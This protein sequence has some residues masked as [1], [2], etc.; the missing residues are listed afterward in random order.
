MENRNKEFDYTIVLD[1]NYTGPD[2]KT[3]NR[4]KPRSRLQQSL[5]I[6]MRKQTACIMNTRRSVSATR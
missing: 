3:S 4:R 2:R 6:R 1:G 5:M